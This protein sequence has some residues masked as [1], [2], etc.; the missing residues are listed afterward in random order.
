MSA[1]SFTRT[2]NSST[3]TTGNSMEIEFSDGMKIDMSGPYRIIRESDGLYVVGRGGA[4]PVDTLDEALELIRDLRR[5]DTRFHN[6]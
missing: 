2:R 4:S 1:K 5:T 3:N 6:Q